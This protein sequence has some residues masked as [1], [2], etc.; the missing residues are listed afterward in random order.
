MPFL[1]M[2]ACMYVGRK[3]GLCM[4]WMYVFMYVYVGLQYV[5]LQAY[6]NHMYLCMCVYVG[7]CMYESCVFMCVWRPM[8]VCMYVS[9]VCMFY[10]FNK[11]KQK[12][13]C[14]EIDWQSLFMRQ[15]YFHWS[16]TFQ[17]FFLVQFVDICTFLFVVV[18]VVF[19]YV[20]F[21]VN[22]NYLWTGQAITKW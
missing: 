22:D 13:V 18:V 11:K 15:N 16:K 14:Q 5:H 8:Y 21:S 12:K 10:R 4:Y 20:V 1:C 6:M 3:E 19:N 9:Y 17:L 7:L 2:Y